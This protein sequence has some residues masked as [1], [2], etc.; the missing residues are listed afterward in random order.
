MSAKL[1]QLRPAEDNIQSLYDMSRDRQEDTK[2]GNTLN[3]NT[4]KTLQII[5]V[6]I[7]A[8]SQIK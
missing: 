6:H 2:E 5:T 8:C 3:Y 7:K 4:V 1:C